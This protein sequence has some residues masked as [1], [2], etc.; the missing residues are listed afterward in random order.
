MTA[1]LYA[2]LFM[3]KHGPQKRIKE[4]APTNP[5]IGQTSETFVTP[6][7]QSSLQYANSRLLRRA[8]QLLRN[9]SPVMAAAQFRIVVGSMI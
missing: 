9:P 1:G 4:K 3:P 8:D 5:C 7:V 6:T 2:M